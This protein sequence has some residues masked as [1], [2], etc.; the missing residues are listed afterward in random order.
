MRTTTIV[1]VTGRSRQPW[2]L[3]D[4]PPQ[5]RATARPVIPDRAAVEDPADAPV[6]EAQPVAMK[7]AANSNADVRRG[8][9]RQV[10]GSTIPLL[11]RH[12]WPVTAGPRDKASTH[13][14]PNIP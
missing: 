12:P 8:P 7:V 4:A 10:I 9:P 6:A 3:E 1:A 14:L 5:T 11:R 13:P 2:P